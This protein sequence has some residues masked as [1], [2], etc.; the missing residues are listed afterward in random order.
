MSCTPELREF[1]S[2]H[3][4]RQ[5]QTWDPDCCDTEL[6]L[7]NKEFKASMDLFQQQATLSISSV[8]GIGSDPSVAK[9]LGNN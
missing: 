8:G 6:Q 7:I 1:Q 4:P 2:P 9:D 3:P 5:N